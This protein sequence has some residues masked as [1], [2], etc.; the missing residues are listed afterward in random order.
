M[1]PI[2]S[3]NKKESGQM[4]A[5][6]CIGLALMALAWILISYSLFLANNDIRTEMAARYAAW[7]QGASG[8]GTAVIAS[9]VDQYFFFQSGLSTV[10]NVPPALI[11][12]VITGN[13][14]DG[15]FKV[16]VAFGVS[17]PNSSSN[18]F[19]F[20]ML[21]THVPFMPDSMMATYSVSSTCQW[22][23]TGETWRSP[24]KALE[25]IWNT[26]KDTVTSTIKKML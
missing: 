4:M 23:G 12:D 11:G 18:P 19:P 20:N 7:H 3:S 9:Q 25:G 15:P 1:K 26:L 22:D 10:S 21:K 6:A 17:D 8:D 24:G 2:N 13:M 16:K 14:P 5:E